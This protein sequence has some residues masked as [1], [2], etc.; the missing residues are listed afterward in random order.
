MHSTPEAAR[1]RLTYLLGGIAVLLAVAATSCG[2]GGGPPVPS[3]LGLLT[4]PSSTAQSGVVLPQQPVVQLRDAAGHPA[5]VGGVT[6]IVSLAGGGVLGGTVAVVTGSDGRAVFTDL[7]ITGLVGSRTLHFAS[8]GLTQAVSGPIVLAAGP[9]SRLRLTTQPATTARAGIALTTQPVVQVQDGGGNNVSQAGVGVTPGVALGGGT[10]SSAAAV[11]TDAGGSA[12]F[13]NLAILG[14]SGVKRLT[15]AAAGLAP[16]TS[17]N[18]S[19]SGGVASTMVVVTQPADTARSSV[20]L[21]RQPAIQLRDGNGN[22]APEA[23]TD[24]TVTVLSGG[25]TLSGATTVQTNGSGRAAFTDLA[26]TGAGPQTLR[27]TVSGMTPVDGSATTLPYGLTSGAPQSGLAAPAGSATWYVIQVPAGANELVVTSGGGSGDPDLYVRS[28][29]LPTQT[30]AGCVSDG[31]STAETCTLT[32]PAAGAYYV[33]MYAFASYSD[34]TLTATASSGRLAMVTQPADTARSGAALARQPAVRLVDAGGANVNQAGVN[35]SAALASGSGALAGQLTVA[36][37]ATGV[38]TFT[39]LVISGA[40]PFALRFASSGR[41]GT[42]SAAVDLPATLVSGV[43]LTQGGA[44]GSTRWYAVQVTAGTTNLVVDLQPGSGNADIYVRAGELPTRSTYACAGT[45]PTA[46]E[47]C[48]ISNPAAGTWFV[49]LDAPAAFADVVLTATVTGGTACTLASA[50][51]A[52][53]DRLPDCVETNTRSFVSTVNTGTNPF[54]ADTD[55]DGLND[56]DEVLGSVAGL[57]LPALGVSPLRRDILM[58]YDWFDDAN[59]CSAHSHRPTAGTITMVTAAFAAAPVANPDGTTGITLINDFGQGGA[60]GGGNSI[61]DPDGVIDGGVNNAEFS[62]HKNGNFA[63]NRRGYF[64][65]VLLPHRYGTN[66]G[67]SGQAELPGNDMIVSLYC[68]G[69]DRN[70]A[71]TI[72]HELG[73]NL[74][75]RHGGFENRNYK[76]NYNSVMNYLYQFPGIDTDCTPP[77]NGLL[78]Y[79]TGSRIPLD[80]SNLDERVGVCGSP[81]GPGWDWNLDGDSNDFGLVRDINVDGSGT[82]DFLFYV[83]SDHDDWAGLA[84]TGL[85]DADGAML[86]MREIISCPDVP[87]HLL[88]PPRR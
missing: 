62:G 71:N 78:S 25:G 16:D 37:D 5:G 6:V 26:I 41:A 10:L 7:A 45:S 84:F 49:L 61:G 52:D 27:F 75:L 38:A 23:G 54:N 82:G 22:D 85:T 46:S 79:S 13:T 24:V 81:P 29:G 68:A 8:E 70:V 30:V 76:P 9:A 65:Y 57:D 53:N 18:V 28:G 74:L 47:S 39:N 83:L 35:V 40:G 12:A 17:Q 69:S 44:A 21:S 48:A 50:G 14:T 15:F 34:V 56:G 58:E 59:E 33:L 42:T 60:F 2:D 31:S 86:V 43:S 77:G 64:H 51:D 1:L 55:G 80:E 87:L 63:A 72:M 19:L 20:V 88:P 73:H 3:Q 36:T 66:S 67:S 32:N 11:P 4:A